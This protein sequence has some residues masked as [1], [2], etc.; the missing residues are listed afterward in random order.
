MAVDKAKGKR[1]EAK[2]IDFA[3]ITTVNVITV[4]RLQKTIEITR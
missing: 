4:D 1:Q 3:F 2:G